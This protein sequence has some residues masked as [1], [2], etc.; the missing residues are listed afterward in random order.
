METDVEAQAAAIL[1]WRTG[2]VTLWLYALFYVP[3]SGK[4]AA[5]LIPALIR[6][7]TRLPPGSRRIIRLQSFEGVEWRL[8]L[9]QSFLQNLILAYRMFTEGISPKI[10]YLFHLCGLASEGIRPNFLFVADEWGVLHHKV[11]VSTRKPPYSIAY[12]SEITVIL[13]VTYKWTNFVVH[14]R[15]FLRRDSFPDQWHPVS[16][17][18]SSCSRK[19]K[20]SNV[21]IRILSMTLRKKH[22]I[23]L[24][25]GTTVSTRVMRIRS[26]KQHLWLL[27]TVNTCQFCSI[28]LW[29]GRLAKQGTAFFCNLINTYVV[30]YLRHWESHVTLKPFRK[31]MVLAIYSLTVLQ[32]QLR[33]VLMF[34]LAN[35]GFD[36]RVICNIHEKILLA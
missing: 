12:L 5:A 31:A 35:A 9:L 2:P 22:T 8:D 13:Q 24:L 29:F 25:K 1:S 7:F 27:L 6:L 36:W 30:C 4:N 16:R 18:S 23:S 33:F 15:P 32:N 3:S 20:Y 14:S 34:G 10:S 26:V 17:P 21:D 28:L 19:R 11:G